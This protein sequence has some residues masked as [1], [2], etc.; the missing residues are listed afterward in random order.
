MSLSLLLVSWMA[1]IAAAPAPAPPPALLQIYREP[2]NAGAETAYDRVESD[3]ARACARL[4][5]PHPYLALESLSGPREAWWLNG[6]DSPADRKKVAEAWAA[7]TEA[8]AAIGGN[9]KRK[10]ALVGK[11]TETIALYRPDLSHGEP[12]RLGHGRFVVI[13]SGTGTPALTGTVYETDDRTR[14]VL[15]PA[16]TRAEADGL[17]AK[18]RAR[19]FAVR[20]S[21][22]HPDEDWFASDPE[23]WSGSLPSPS[24]GTDGCRTVSS[25]GTDTI[26]VDGSFEGSYIVAFGAKDAPADSLS[27]FAPRESPDGGS[28]IRRTYT[29]ADLPVE[30]PRGTVRGFQVG[31]T[32]PHASSDFWVTFAGS[33]DGCRPAKTN[34]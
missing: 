8:L 13:W 11:A 2:I 9:A 33:A 24:S 3:I 27:V 25:S 29:R 14:Y 7:S 5:C 16:G 28:D 17:A 18:S 1:V 15:V 31:V 32:G 10:A 30:L 12:W 22:S 19:V 21:W 4:R 20:P 26:E 34:R 23:L 6:Y